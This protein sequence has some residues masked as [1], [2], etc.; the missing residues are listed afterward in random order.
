M[1]LPM[2]QIYSSITYTNKLIILRMIIFDVT[3]NNYSSKL[4]EGEGRGYYINQLD[5]EISSH[6]H[7]VKYSPGES[8]TPTWFET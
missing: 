8:C 3:I 7:N 6:G 4:L 1:K 2:D 5:H